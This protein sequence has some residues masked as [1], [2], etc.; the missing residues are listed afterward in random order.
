MHANL[1]IA[2]HNQFLDWLPPPPPSSPVK[3]I[4]GK[5]S[6]E[7]NVMLSEGNHSC[8]WLHQGNLFKKWITLTE[9]LRTLAKSCR[10]FAKFCSN[11][12][13]V[14]LIFFRIIQ[15][16]I[17]YICHLGEVKLTYLKKPYIILCTTYQMA[18]LLLFNEA[19]TLPCR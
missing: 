2:Q 13:N 19:S 11:Y 1:V 6:V 17:I 12:V 10:L 16:L 18:V 4:E 5:R 3:A 14:G 8:W 9:M 15:I 7:V